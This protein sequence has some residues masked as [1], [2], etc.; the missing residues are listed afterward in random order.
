MSVNVYVGVDAQVYVCIQRL[1]LKLTKPL[2]TG[3]THM[4][5]TL[6]LM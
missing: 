5:P 6:F 3:I 1:D 4:H 2:D